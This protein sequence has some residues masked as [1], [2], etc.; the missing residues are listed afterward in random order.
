[1]TTHYEQLLSLCRTVFD[2]AA[3]G[4]LLTWD[5]QTYMPPGGAQGRALQLATL[6]RLAHEHFISDE[7]GEA[8][9]RAS[10]EVAGLDPDS[11]EVR[12]VSRLKRDFEKKRRVSS[13]WVETFEEAVALAFQAWQ[14]AREESDFPSFQPHLEKIVELRRSYAHFYAP[15]DN[16]YDPLLDDYEPDMTVAEVAA[17]FDEL[18]PRQIALVEAITND[19]APLDDSFLRQPFDVQKQWDFGI[20]VIGDIGYDFSRGRQDKAAHPFTIAFNLGDVRITNRIDP[21]RFGPGLFGS[22]HEAGHGIYSQGVSPSL[23]RIPTLSGAALDPSHHP[24]LG[25]HESQS[26]LVENLI[27]RSRAFWVAYYPRL[28]SIFPEQLSKV[29]REDFY[30]AINRVEPS[31]IRVE[32]DEATYNLHIMLRFEIELGM[33]EGSMTVADLPEV[34][35]SKMQEYLGLTP[36]NDALGVLQDIHWSHGYIGYFPTYTLGNLI[37]AQWWHKMQGDLPEMEKQIESGQFDDLIGWLRENVHR[38]G[39]KFSPVELIQRVTG[40][41]LSAEPY[42]EYLEGKYTDIYQIA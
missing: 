38:H 9:E 39:A 8:I 34:W 37:A 35:N 18:R 32:A 29:G 17:I 21:N 10:E 16:I 26:R 42:L 4:S 15:Y 28:Q 5:Q 36:P 40:E 11:D 6:N 24:S 1:M 31:L 25:L 23:E 2:L 30:R 7:F 3:A 27:G 22:M 20:E 13:E 12:V 14:A 19:G 41:G 33:M